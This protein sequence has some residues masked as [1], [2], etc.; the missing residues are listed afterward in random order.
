[1]SELNAPVKPITEKKIFFHSLGCPKNLVDTE[2]MLGISVG[3]G[4]KVVPDASDANVIVVNTCS[5]INDSK[6]ESIDAILDAAEQ[7]KSG[8]CERLIVTGCLPQRYKADLKVSFPE[9]DA[10]VGTGQYGQLLDFVAGK[11]EEDFGF[12][13]P[14]YI[15]NEHTPRINSL[16]FYKA[17]LKVSE[18][19]IKACAFCIIPKIRG[20][21]RSRTIDSLV[22]EAKTLVASGAKEL[23]LIAQDLTDYGRD[24]RDGTNLPG[25]LRALVQIEGLEWIRLL[26]VYPDELSD[27]LLELIATEEKI[28]KYIDTPVQHINDRM[29]ALMNRKVSGQLIRDRLARLRERIPGVFIR[30]T[31]I[32]G[33]PGE[34]EEAFEELKAFIAEAEFD[35][36]GVFAYSKEENTKS[37]LLGGQLPEDIKQRR[38]DELMAI[39]QKSSAKRLKNMVGQV[40]PVLVEETSEESEFL[41]Q[42]RHQGQASEIDGHVLIRA[43]AIERGKIALVKLERAMEY[44]YIGR[45]VEKGIRKSRAAAKSN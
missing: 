7:K 20:T 5:F 4:F 32:A 35:H 13:H 33:Y 12:K 40:V 9:V 23:N 31:V 3:D 28:C 1:M 29:L 44:D 41:W 8:K 37:Y 30:S 19:C 34:T 18:G 25:L 22:L 36:L 10:F 42:G 2:V 39:Q 14:K 17:Y 45:V 26:Y 6:R 27:E 24:L 11:K 21:L 16:P 15:H 43:G 38:R